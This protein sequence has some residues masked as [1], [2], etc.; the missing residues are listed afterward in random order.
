MTEG[1]R[2]FSIDGKGRLATQMLQQIRRCHLFIE[3]GAEGGP[4]PRGVVGVRAMLY[5]AKRLEQIVVVGLGGGDGLIV[6]GHQVELGV[7]AGEIQRLRRT[8]N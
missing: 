4:D 1:R 5:T 6:E 7:G 8:A 3:E 2:W